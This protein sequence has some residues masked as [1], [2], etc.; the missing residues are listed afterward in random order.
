M[1]VHRA[2]LERLQQS[3][4]ED[5][6]TNYIVCLTETFGPEYVRHL[7]RWLEADAARDAVEM[8]SSVEER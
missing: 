1:S 4:R 5:L 8:L 6:C 2:N 3:G 7:E